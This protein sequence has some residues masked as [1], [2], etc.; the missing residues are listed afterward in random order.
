MGDHRGLVLAA[1]SSSAGLI[2]FT[3][4]LMGP[5]LKF[6]ASE[7]GLGLWEA[8]MLAS[9]V[10]VGYM[11]SPFGGLLSDRIGELNSIFLA[12]VSLAILSLLVSSSGGFPLCFASLAF[13]GLSIGTINS[14]TT[15]SVAKAY[16]SSRVWA[17]NILHAFFGIGSLS[18]PTIAG[19]LL[20][21][22]SSWRAVYLIPALLSI[23]AGL[24]TFAGSARAKVDL[25]SAPKLD[26]RALS[27]V[28]N[29]AFLALAL[30][31]FA[32]MGMAIGSTAWLPTYL[33]LHKGFDPKFAG[34]TI[35]LFWGCVGLGRL[36]LAKAPEAIGLERS[37]AIFAILA[38]FLSWAGI[39]A[40][41]QY[42]TMALWA[43]S[44]LAFSI[45][46]PSVLALSVKKVPGMAGGAMGLL[47]SVG[48][49]GSIFSQWAIGFL[50]GLFSLAISIHCVSLFAFAM[51]IIPLGML[52]A[53]GS[54][55][56]GTRA[57]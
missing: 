30:A 15:L 52:F 29:R 44:G 9:A 13:L 36:A 7:F 4:A 18:G 31:T 53:S 48:M 57:G 8:G 21:Y 40:K 41:G 12:L 26:R 25:A 5:S 51:G 49:A 24:L 54:R 20:S 46:L 11:F 32:H 38:G 43:L 55:G 3:M 37:I 35:G 22:G 10:S 17:L 45:T 50:G 14:I 33:M 42:A 27:I 28:G 39:Y 6:M 19:L 34:L 2:G 56:G 47:F 16:P 1:C 23:P